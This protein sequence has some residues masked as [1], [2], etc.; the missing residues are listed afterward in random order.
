MTDAPFKWTCIK[1]DNEISQYQEYCAECEEKQYRK[2]GGF[3]YLPLLSLFAL[4][5]SYFSSLQIT[6]Q[7]GLIT[8][9]HA[10]IAQSGY[11]FY[12]LR[13]KLFRA[14]LYHLHH[15]T[16]LAQKETVTPGL[17]NLAG[18]RRG[19]DAARSRL[20]GLP[21]SVSCAGL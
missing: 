13:R 20:H 6:L 18:R 9:G 16:L 2:I 19:V 12:C 14:S 1:C 21:L 8:A 5:Y 17:Y 4:G 7:A 15:L 3:L 10:P 11:F